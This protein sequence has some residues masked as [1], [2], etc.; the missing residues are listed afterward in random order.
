MPT[1]TTTNTMTTTAP[2]PP[3]TPKLP[4]T[5][6]ATNSCM[7]CKTWGRPCPLYTKPVP[8][9]SPIK[10]KWSYEDWDGEELREKE[11]KERA[12]REREGRQG[13]IG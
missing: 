10:S 9:P 1:F 4:A 3:A 5:S 8:P 12:S 2:N 7:V 13:E 11:K 6:T